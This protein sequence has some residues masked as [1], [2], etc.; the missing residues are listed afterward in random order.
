MKR[1]LG[2]LPAVISLA[3]PCAPL[4]AADTP[5]PVLWNNADR[6]AAPGL[7]H[8]SFQSEAM[9]T[10]VGYNVS[11][12][13]GYETGSRRYPVVY[14]LHGAGGDEHSDAAAFAGLVAEHVQAGKIPPAL[15]VF[16][17]GGPRSG[18]RDNPETGARV[19][20]MIVKELV[21]R[22]DREFRTEARRE[23]RTVVGFSM[24]GAG[25]VRFALKYPEVFSAAGAWA[26][27]FRFL[28]RPENTLPADYAVP[29]LAQ[30]AGRVRLLLVVGTKDS[31]LASHPPLVQNLVEAKF[32]FEL[33]VLQDV[34][35][36]PGAY[37]VRSGDKML[38]F[39]TATFVN[40]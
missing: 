8:R 5:A 4:L 40:R 26:G 2:F 24:G 23:M 34:E 16:P 14:F 18:Y 1:L 12:P 25:A 27:A 19:E 13:R 6:P 3:M 22:V 9:G 31:T 11:L 33:D 39:L 37:Y 28:S 7:E 21:A 32:P 30:Q 15:C 36:D 38:R 29:A 35:H 17:N 20:T 10:A